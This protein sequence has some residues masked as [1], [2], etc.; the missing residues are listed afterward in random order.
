M[1]QF[2]RCD[3]AR[4]VSH[5]YNYTS[6][7]PVCKCLCQKSDSFGMITRDLSPKD[8][9][10]MRLTRAWACVTIVVVCAAGLASRLSSII[11]PHSSGKRSL[12]Y[13]ALLAA[14]VNSDRPARFIGDC[15]MRRG[16]CLFPG[17]VCRR[18]NAPAHG[19]V[20]AW[21]GNRDREHQRLCPT[22]CPVGTGNGLS[23][24]GPRAHRRVLSGVGPRRQRA[25]ADAGD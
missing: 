14:L 18:A 11:E 6:I 20:C 4:C 5:R 15:A 8:K 13:E 9:R 17:I 22:Q 2:E 7:R 3:S 10:A 19:N 24:S 16:S 23:D 12:F 21:P 1:V 25:L